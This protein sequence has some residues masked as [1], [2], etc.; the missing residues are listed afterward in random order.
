[1]ENLKKFLEESKISLLP[2]HI[3]DVLN[4]ILKSRM[5]LSWK[6]GDDIYN[7]RYFDGKVLNALKANGIDLRGKDLTILNGKGKKIKKIKSEAIWPIPFFT[8][9]F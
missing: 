8:C 4:T 3:N 7:A 5:P 6:P 9:L 1:M 2:T